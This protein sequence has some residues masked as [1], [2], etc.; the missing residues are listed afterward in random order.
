MRGNQGFS[1]TSLV[2]KQFLSSVPKGDIRIAVVPFESHRVQ[3]RIDSSVF[4]T[5]DS[6][7]QVAGR[8]PEP[9]DRNNTALYS[10]VVFGAARLDAE[11]KSSPAGTV[12]GMLVITDGM[13]EVYL[14]QSDDDDP[15]LLR[16]DQ[17][18]IDAARAA[19]DQA[20]PRLWILGLGGRIDSRQ[21]NAL[22]KGFGEMDSLQIESYRLQQR[23]SAIGASFWSGWEAGFPINQEREELGRGWAELQIVPA[24]SVAPVRFGWRPPLVALPAFEAVLDPT[25]LVERGGGPGGATPDALDRRIPLGVFSAA[26]LCFLWLL[27]PRFLWPPVAPPVAVVPEGVAPQSAKPK[28]VPIVTGALRTDVKEIAPRSPGDSTASKAR[29]VT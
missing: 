22:A 1:T 27:I 14:K 20:R 18:G 9:I 25:L 16:T 23:V 2:L 24:G 7:R 8:L 12:G 21:L 13:N 4:T 11:V 17:H 28:I 10:A 19:L 5:P 6:A 26:L 3:A 15:G 29:R